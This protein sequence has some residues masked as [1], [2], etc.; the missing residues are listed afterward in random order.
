MPRS[1]APQ[2]AP[3][4]VVTD[5]KFVGEVHDADAVR[6]RILKGIEGHEW[7]G[8]NKEWLDEI[9]E[10]GVRGDFQNRGYFEV[11]VDGIKSQVLESTPTQQRVVATF[12]IKEGDRFATGDFTFVNANP[13]TPLV[14]SDSE[15]RQQI[16]LAKGDWVGTDQLRKGITRIS[17]LFIA[18]GY[19]EA[20]IVPAFSIDR[21]N[22]SISATFTVHQGAVHPAAQ[23]QPSLGEN[24]LGKFQ[25]I[26]PA[27]LSSGK[28]QPIPPVIQSL[29]RGLNRPGPDTS[30]NKSRRFRKRCAF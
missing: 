19:A 12:N 23:P 8:S 6:A 18:R 16:Q 25:P 3:K 7:D 2:P 14:I 11:N 5:V 20:K 15:L 1:A 30:F 4:I 29:P 24:F 13:E 26:P 9:A 17:Q 28:V 10:V 22:H 21:N 27:T